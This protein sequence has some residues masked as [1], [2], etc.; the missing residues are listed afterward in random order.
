VPGAGNGA[1]AACSGFDCKLS[2][3]APTIDR[4][5]DSMKKRILVLGSDGFIGR[6]VV[7]ALAATDWALPVASG[8]GPSGPEVTSA[9]RLQLD[10]TD[11]GAVR[12]A[13]EGV[14]GVVNC[15]SGGREAIEGSAGALFSAAA[16]LKEP[17]IVVHFSSMAV[18]GSAD[19]EVDES[20]PLRGDLGPYS[21]AKVV[22]ERLA[23]GYPRTVILRPGIVY[24]PRS[25]LWSRD[26]GRLLL[27]RRLGDLG[28]D[29]AGY[30]N[31]VYVDDVAAAV[32]R[33]LGTPGAI[34]Q[35]LNLS[36]SPVPTWNEYFC[37]Y[38]A[39]LRAV[40]VRRVGALRLQWELRAIGPLLKMAEMMVKGAGMNPV[41]LPPPIRPWLLRQCRHRI[42]MHSGRAQSLLNVQWTPLSE[43][44]AATARWL[45][46]A[47]GNGTVANVP[48]GPY[49]REP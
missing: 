22:A 17:P 48:A 32:V 40:P 16:A 21:A 39:E 20:S 15:V 11:S 38:A 30:C 35:A 23:A 10:A 29:G 43:G 1:L 27:A 45:L 31:L 4:A 42:L 2:L 12:R 5:F 25:I 49:R 28:S 7:A 3:E 44:L 9:S 41:A 34:G 18:Y 46:A 14:A 19:G 6:R 26:I 24:G 8:R 47:S 36:A 37:C 33:A 13:L